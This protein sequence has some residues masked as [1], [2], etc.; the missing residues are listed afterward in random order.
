MNADGPSS[1]LRLYVCDL[2]DVTGGS[3]MIVGLHAWVHGGKVVDGLC[4]LAISPKGGLAPKL[5]G[6]NISFDMT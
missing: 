3:S 4:S 1:Y 5:S 2:H 6:K